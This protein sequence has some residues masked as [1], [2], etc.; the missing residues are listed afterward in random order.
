M[1]VLKARLRNRWRTRKYK[2]PFASSMHYLLP[3]LLFWQ[4]ELSA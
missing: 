2:W 4:I 3:N 1:L